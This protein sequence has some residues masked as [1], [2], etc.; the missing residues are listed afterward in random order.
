MRAHLSY[1]SFI[2]SAAFSFP[3]SFSNP[4][5]RSLRSI[6]FKLGARIGESVK[7]WRLRRVPLLLSQIWIWSLWF[8]FW[9][10]NRFSWFSSCFRS[11]YKDFLDPFLDLMRRG[12]P[13]ILTE[14]SM[15]Y[16]HW[17]WISVVQWTSDLDLRSRSF[18]F[19]I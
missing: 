16:I 19:W 14:N 2:S 3:F 17:L 11:W 18:Y 1:L 5:P 12:I 4:N 8:S 6:I 9:F 13:S 15:S 7:N 10:M